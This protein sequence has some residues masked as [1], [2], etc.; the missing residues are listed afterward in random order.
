MRHRSAW[1]RVIM[2]KPLIYS[3]TQPRIMY[4]VEIMGGGRRHPGEPPRPGRG[5]L[6]L[7]PF[8]RKAQDI[9]DRLR[10]RLT[11]ADAPVT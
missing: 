5:V 1:L 2:P 4:N 3:D 8:R 9:G 7:T 10:Y 6:V 11:C